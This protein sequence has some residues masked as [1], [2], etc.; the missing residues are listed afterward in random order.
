MTE[1]AF[2]VIDCARTA[3][4]GEPMPPPQAARNALAA[5][6]AIVRIV[7][8]V[9]GRRKAREV[10]DDVRR[11][12]CVE[13][14]E[15]FP[16]DADVSNGKYDLFGVVQFAPLLL[17]PVTGIDATLITRTVSSFRWDQRRNEADV[18]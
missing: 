2:A 9:V 11:I 12:R 14:I 3:C 7:V 13:I 15:A 10:A 4:G 18:A 16:R 5:R 6:N 1:A 17:E 8:V